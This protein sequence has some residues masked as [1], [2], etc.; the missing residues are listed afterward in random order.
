MKGHM[1]KQKA[2]SCLWTG[3]LHV[4]KTSKHPEKPTASMYSLQIPITDS[5]KMEKPILTL[6]LL[7]NLMGPQIAKTILKKKKK[8][9]SHF[10]ISKLT[11]K[12]Q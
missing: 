10:L 12:L 8:E 9:A 6:T 3:K 11:R 5:A 2:T 7:W 4:V 1:N